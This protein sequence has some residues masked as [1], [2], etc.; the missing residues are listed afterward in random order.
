MQIQKQNRPDI[1]NSGDASLSQSSAPT[2]TQKQH[3]V[4]NPNWLCVR[5]FKPDVKTLRSEPKLKMGLND[6]AYSLLQKEP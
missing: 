2:E 4:L 1:E 6:A 3:N 5:I